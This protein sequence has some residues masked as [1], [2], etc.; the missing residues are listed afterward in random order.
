[1]L[2]WR[3]LTAGETAACPLYRHRAPLIATDHGIFSTRILQTA[4]ILDHLRQQNSTADHVF[5]ILDDALI[6]YQEH[7]LDSIDLRAP[8]EHRPL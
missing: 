8:D 3:D 1:M 5:A 4:R 6:D 2:I 7:L